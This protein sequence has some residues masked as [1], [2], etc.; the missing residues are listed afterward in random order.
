[1]NDT[2][3][4]RE[5]QDLRAQMHRNELAPLSDRKEAQADTAELMRDTAMVAERIEWVLNGNFGRGAM[6]EMQRIQSAKRG[7]R[8][9]SA[10]QLIAALDCFCP[11]RHAIS[12]WNGLTVDEQSALSAAIRSSL[13]LCNARIGE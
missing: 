6:L 12:A 5:M 10:M 8:E 1:M 13:D 7:N 9:A 3:H 4:L 11:A 2:Y